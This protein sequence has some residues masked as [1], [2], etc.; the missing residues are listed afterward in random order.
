M[1]KN[2]ENSDR[3]LP[4]ISD[5]AFEKADLREVLK[6][7]YFQL[8]QTQ[9]LVQKVKEDTAKIKQLEEALSRIT[10]VK[11]R[12]IKLRFD[13]R[14]TEL[15]ITDKFSIPFKSESQ[16]ALLLSIMFNK[17]NQKPKPRKWQCSE[18]AEAFDKNGLAMKTKN[19]VYKAA[20]RISERVKQETG[21][22]GLF[23]VSKN[24]FFIVNSHKLL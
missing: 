3:L 5:E 1:N 14:T 18:V 10:F 20:L 16:E 15:R 21:I 9:V 24:E 2:K 4:I 19:Q 6:A 8:I 23:S 11:S 12:W 22:D 7:L 13:H 17:S